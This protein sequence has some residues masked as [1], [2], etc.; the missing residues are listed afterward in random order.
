MF[1][2]LVLGCVYSLGC[3][4]V[5]K[6]ITPS[7]PSQASAEFGAA[8][9]VAVRVLIYTRPLILCS[10]RTTFNKTTLWQLCP[11]SS[12]MRGLLS[13]MLGSRLH[14]LQSLSELI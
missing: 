7:S 3:S 13:L 9:K 10:T 14:T 6:D 8:W 2:S 12:G 1:I 4:T 5:I 11:G